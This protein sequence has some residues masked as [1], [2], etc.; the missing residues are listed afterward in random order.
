MREEELKFLRGLKD[1]GSE[2]GLDYRD[3]VRLIKLV[4]QNEEPQEDR[5]KTG[6]H[7]LLNCDKEI[8][9][10]LEKRC[11]KFHEH[12]VQEILDFINTNHKILDIH[13]KITPIRR[14]KLNFDPYLSVYL[15]LSDITESLRDGKWVS[16]LDSA[17]VIDSGGQTLIESM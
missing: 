15:S 4:A 13:E 3:T 12:L 1:F 2:C 11:I 14:E 6:K 7:P 16:S 8:D 17:F 10:D 9:E 5:W